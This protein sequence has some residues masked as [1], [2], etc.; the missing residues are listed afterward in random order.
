M[1]IAVCYTVSATGS[2]RYWV[3]RTDVS[4]P[5]L[6]LR[7]ATVLSAYDSK[8]SGN[9]ISALSGIYC[10]GRIYKILSECTMEVK[11]I[12]SDDIQQLKYNLLSHGVK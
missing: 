6:C 3:K 8:G 4:F 12:L 1:V 9:D 11:M 2:N 10:S 5:C 7:Y